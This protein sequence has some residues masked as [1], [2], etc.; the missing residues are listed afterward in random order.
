MFLVEEGEAELNKR[1]AASTSIRRQQAN[2][3][4]RIPS[5]SRQNRNT[6]SGAPI[7]SPSPLDPSPISLLG[8]FMGISVPTTM[9]DIFEEGRDNH[10]E[11]GLNLAS[12]Q[13]VLSERA[14]LLG[15]KSD[16][17]HLTTTSYS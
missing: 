6:L 1:L 2:M 15:T 12:R 17:D 11:S 14:P 9:N 4:R 3:R 7:F 8:A 16:E 5:S 10:L 13:Q